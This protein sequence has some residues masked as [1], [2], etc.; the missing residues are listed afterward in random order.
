MCY[1]FLISPIAYATIYICINKWQ[2][3]C[4]FFFAMFFLDYW[5][6]SH[7]TPPLRW[8]NHSE[9]WG[10]VL[11]RKPAWRGWIWDT[12]GPCYESNEE[13]LTQPQIIIAHRLQSVETPVRWIIRISMCNTIRWLFMLYLLLSNPLRILNTVCK[14]IGPVMHSQKFVKCP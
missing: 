9:I 4:I 12:H 8:Q 11:W 5:S 6:H 2:S 10:K 1:E 14:W 7:K 13:E 3:G